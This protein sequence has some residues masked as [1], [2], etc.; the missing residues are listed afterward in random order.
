MSL[1]V[2]LLSSSLVSGS[3][4]LVSSGLV[5]SGLAS[6][7]DSFGFSSMSSKVGLAFSTTGTSPSSKTNEALK[8][9]AALSI[10]ANTSSALS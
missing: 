10:V 6:S 2:S 1:A 9:E 4:G 5:S 7:S 8:V 3:S